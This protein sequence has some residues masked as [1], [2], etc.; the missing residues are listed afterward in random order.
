MRFDGVVDFARNENLAL[1]LL[2]GSRAQAGGREDSD[3]DLA[4]LP[5]NSGAESTG[6]ERRL[7]NALKRSDLD[8]LWL[9]HASPLAKAQVASTAQVLYEDR[10]YR[11]R[12]FAHDAKLGQSDSRVWAESDLRYI[13]RSLERDWTMDRD[14]VLRKLAQLAEYLEQLEQIMEVD[15]VTFARDFRVHRVAER[16]VELLVECAGKLNTELAQSLAKIPASDYYSSFFSLAATGWL[17]N[18]TAGRLAT[19]AGLRNRLVHQYED[20]RLPKLY[21]ACQESLADWRTYLA[22]LTNRLRQSPGS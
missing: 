4:L 5:Q 8:L 18:D 19:L 9:P 3:W 13:T 21:Q 6:I 15:E 12:Q 1:V 7:I 17:D 14:L 20:I 16:Q 11:F 2:F 10:P 22:S